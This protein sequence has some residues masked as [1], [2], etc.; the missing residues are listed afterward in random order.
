VELFGLIVVV[1]AVVVAARIVKSRRRPPPQQMPT[2]EGVPTFRVVTLGPRGAGKTL[3]LA[4]MFQQMQTPSGRSFFLTAPY[5]QVVQLNSWFTEVADTSKAWPSGTAVGD[6]REFV[7]TVRTRAPSG[8]V[9][10]VMR[11]SYLEYAGGLLT[12]AQAPG[13]TAQTELLTRI[14]SAHALVGIIDGYRVRQ[15][16]DGH[17]EGQMR[18]QQSLTAM[19]NLMM[20]ASCPI[21]FIITKWDILRDIDVDENSRLRRV[22]KYLMSN[23]GFADLVQAHNMHR[24][25]RL[26]P[27]S[28]VGPDFAELDPEGMIAKLPD[29]EMHPTN[30]DVPLAA[31]VP[32]VF[33]QVEHSM[34]KAAL[35]AALDRVR[36]QTRMGPAAALAEL[37]T[38][39]G[40]TA[41]KALGPL[42][43]QA[44]SFFG[45]VAVELLGSD[46]GPDRKTTVDRQLSEVDRAIEEFHL[47][48]RR[49]LRDFQSRVDVLEGRLPSSRLSGED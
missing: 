38:F 27:V 41:A 34:D 11:L 19:I 28:A 10:T 9:H 21:T 22:R 2:A 7:F 3:L 44:A 39:V 24:V 46:P 20:L 17:H 43:S 5:D 42:G 37:G 35:Q 49:V 48:R 25:V 29:G 12:D 16:L 23:Q 31:V 1:V 15:C 32:D 18:L 40:G 8:A 36:R 14:D 6:T 26:I 30:V 13:A 45:D 33:E 4:S 47:A